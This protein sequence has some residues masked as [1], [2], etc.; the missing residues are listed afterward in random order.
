MKTKK[1]NKNILLIITY[2]LT[3]LNM[4]ML[5]F[6]VLSVAFNWFGVVEIVNE[7]MSQNFVA[8]YDFNEYLISFY[9]DAVLSFLICL[10][11]SVFFYKGIKYRVNNP[12]YAR[13]LVIYSIILILTGAY[14]CGIMALITGLVMSKQKPQVVSE[15]DLAQSFL[16]DYKLMAMS[17]AV[18]RLKELR[19]SGAI[20]EEEYYANLNKILEG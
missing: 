11:Y 13:K 9:I 10:Y 3:V 16:S 12:V 6:T 17:E 2:I 18:T 1:R 14:L 5:A 7:I 20:S 19:A 8:G 4:A 15:K